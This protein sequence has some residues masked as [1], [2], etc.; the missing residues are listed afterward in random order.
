M[1]I[2]QK[3][4]VGATDYSNSLFEEQVLIHGACGYI[5]G[6]PMAMIYQAQV[7][8]WTLPHVYTETWEEQDPE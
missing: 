7:E 8:N 3:W 1:T 5:K 2:T 6:I 4:I